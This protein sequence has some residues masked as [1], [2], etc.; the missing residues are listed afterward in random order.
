MLGGF[1]YVFS[2][3]P[4]RLEAQASRCLVYFFVSFLAPSPPF[5]SLLGIVLATVWF[6]PCRGCCCIKT[7]K[8]SGFVRASGA[9]TKGCPHTL[10][11]TLLLTLVSLFNTSVCLLCGNV[12]E[13][14]P[15]TE[16]P[17]SWDGIC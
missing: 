9:T 7:S 8:G 16:T 1:G 15:E 13:L 11:H 12:S 10:R 14:R 6:C 17:Q 2:N 3:K 4:A 5:M